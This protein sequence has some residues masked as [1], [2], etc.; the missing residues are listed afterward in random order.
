L[1]ATP[2]F[3][4]PRPAPAA[5]RDVSARVESSTALKN[6]PIG[7][8]Y[9]AARALDPP[10]LARFVLHQNALRS[11]GADGDAREAPMLRNVRILVTLVLVSSPSLARPE[12][13]ASLD[14]CDADTASRI[15][16]IETRLDDR[17]TYADWWWKGWTAAYG[18]GTVV[19]SVEAGLEN[20]D[21][22]R[23]ADYV[24]GAVKAAFG[25]TRLAL[26]PPTA[27]RGADPMRAVD[28]VDDA[29]CRER[30][31]I[32]EGLLRQ[33]AEESRTRWSWKRHVAN[34]AI[35]LAGGV[36]VAEGFD[37]SRGWTS[38]GVGFAVG[39]AMTLSHPWGGDDDLAEYER[40]FAADRA[41]DRVTWSVAPWGRGGRIMIRF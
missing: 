23:R 22:G 7:A 6:R 30:L 20:D 4:K 17:R 29:A 24:V 12:A 9:R 40:R 26:W 37:E 25:T 10:G 35:N 11:G 1:H 38:A 5:P 34:L 19:E 41:P 3:L 2:T 8:T 31:T 27:R 36:I 14:R 21:T 13:G 18:I 28:P 39:E 15:R 32:G 16:F 33:V